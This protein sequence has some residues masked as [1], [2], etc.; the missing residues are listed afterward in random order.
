MECCAVLYACNCAV[1]IVGFG[2]A[3]VLS[4]RA[5]FTFDPT[6]FVD[7]DGAAA[8]EE[9]V[10]RELDEGEEMGGGAGAGAAAAADDD[11]GDDDEAGTAGVGAGA[12]GGP[13][14]EDEDEEDGEGEGA[15]AAVPPA[16]GG[17]AAVAAAAV[18]FDA[19]LLLDDVDVE[20]PSDDDE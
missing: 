6:L 2:D 16:A 9:Y 19:R 1:G 14:D 10:L 4:G 15:P 11:S 17:D 12:A 18:D 5:L 20:L 3:D 8:D 13:K 7:D